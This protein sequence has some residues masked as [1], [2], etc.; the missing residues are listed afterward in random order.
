MAAGISGVS[1]SDFQS[2]QKLFQVEVE[3]DWS[4]KYAI[5]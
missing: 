4:E 3:Y 1:S 2:A 5:K